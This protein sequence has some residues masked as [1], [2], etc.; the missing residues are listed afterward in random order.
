MHQNKL[1]IYHKMSIRHDWVEKVIHWESCKKLKFDHTARWYIYK[2][3]SVLEN[4]LHKI[5]KD[6]VIQTEQLILTRRPDLVI[7]D[8]KKENLPNSGFCHP[9]RPESENQK[10]QKEGQ[11]FR[12]CKIIKKAME[13][14]GDGDTNCN[15]ST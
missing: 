1:K 12:L 5:L 3:K 14:E 10:K 7:A 15:L 4:E 11:V 9:S 6:F 8:K 2:P 13:H